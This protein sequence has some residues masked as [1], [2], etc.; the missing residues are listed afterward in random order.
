MHYYPI[1]STALPP[2][3]RSPKDLG[4]PQAAGLLLAKGAQGA[5]R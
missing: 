2:G 3:S 4:D 1:S 5:K